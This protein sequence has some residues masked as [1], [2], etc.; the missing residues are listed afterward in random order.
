MTPMMRIHPVRHPLSR[1]RPATPP[2]RRTMAVS[3]NKEILTPQHF[4]SLNFGFSTRLRR[5]GSVSKRHGDGDYQQRGRAGVPSHKLLWCSWD[6]GNGWRKLRSYRK[7]DG[8]PRHAP[9]LPGFF[10]KGE[11]GGPS[12][13]WPGSLPELRV[14]GHRGRMVWETHT[15]T[16]LHFYLSLLTLP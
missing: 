4:G 9:L 14:A 1:V 5:W 13:H 10:H 15:H 2:Y 6:V 3:K 8:R 12:Q 16:S 7:P 11:S